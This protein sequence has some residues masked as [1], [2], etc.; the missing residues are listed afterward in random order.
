MALSMGSGSAQTARDQHLSTL[1]K[2]KP[3]TLVKNPSEP[4]RCWG[5][6]QTTASFDWHLV[7]ARDL[8]ASTLPLEI[9]LSHLNC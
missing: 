2:F 7:T 1:L 4:G 3:M 9:L 6:S 8:G 5:H